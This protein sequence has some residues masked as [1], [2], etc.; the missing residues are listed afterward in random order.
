MS[1]LCGSLEKLIK[2][3]GECLEKGDDSVKNNKLGLFNVDNILKNRNYEQL[4]DGFYEDKFNDTR[5]SINDSLDMNVD[6]TIDNSDNN[7]MLLFGL[8]DSI[9]NSFR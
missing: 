4:S 7:G 6:E 9:D 5:I 2:K 1:S 3:I 8:D